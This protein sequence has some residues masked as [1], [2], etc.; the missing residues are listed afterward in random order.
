M[1]QK[2]MVVNDVIKE[3]PHTLGVFS[4]WGIDSCCGGAKRLEEVAKAHKFDLE[5]LL[6]DLRASETIPEREA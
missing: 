5:K 2:D 6:Q 3:H 1:I 4:R